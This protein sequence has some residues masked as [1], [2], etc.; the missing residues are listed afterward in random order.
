MDGGIFYGSMLGAGFARRTT[1]FEGYQTGM[2]RGWIADFSVFL[3]RFGDL[4][5][6]VLGFGFDLN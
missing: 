2:G 5:W 4:E 1:K 3:G 6:I